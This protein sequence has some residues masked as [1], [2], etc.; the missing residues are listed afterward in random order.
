M[1]EE[2]LKLFVVVPFYNEARSI[3]GTLRAL[4]SQTDKHFSL[5]L[6][7]NASTDASV[8]VV[9]EWVQKNHPTFTLE[10]VSET[11]KGT[12]AASDTGFRYAIERGATHIIRTDADCT[13]RADW[14]SNMKLAFAKGYEFVAGVIKPR[15]DEAPLT[16]ADRLAI[17]TMIFVAEN[18]GKIT[19]RGSQFKYAFFMA[20]GNNLGITA[21]LYL[22][23]GGFPRTKIDDANEDTLL[24]EKVRTLTSRAKRF[25]NVVVYNSIRRVRK[26]GYLNTL[27]WYWERKYR[28]DVIDI[29]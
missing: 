4:N 6:V 20:A 3:T 15:G 10:I 16:L 21:L 19:R 1:P 9:Q 23:A 2:T 25:P 17:P 5:V 29:R 8:A 14:V 26:Y 24:A 11:Q 7:D 27:L 18:L 12:G 22:Q 28:P 13:P